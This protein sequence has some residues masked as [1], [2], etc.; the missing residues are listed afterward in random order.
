MKKRKGTALVTGASGGIGLELA[1]CLARGGYDLVLVARNREKLKEIANTLSKRYNIRAT[2]LVKDLSRPL[3]AQKIFDELQ[4]AETE[5]D[6]L[7]NNA[8][9]GGYGHFA[10]QNTDDILEMMQ[11]N[12]AALTHLTRLFLPPMIERKRGRVLNVASTAAF[13]PGPLMAVY[14]ATKAFV[15]SFSEA[16]SNETQGTG[17]TVTCLCPGPTQSDFQ[18]RAQMSNSRL[19]ENVSMNSAQVAQIGY[20]ALMRGQT[21]VITGKSNAFWAFATRLLPRQKL[22]QIARRVQEQKESIEA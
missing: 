20:R 9:F 12:V 1:N 6:V 4:R 5:I 14:Y 7:V 16:L 11:V 10:E 18:T 21:L 8:G 13:L 3:A 19:F 2:V 15:L 17:V 22:S